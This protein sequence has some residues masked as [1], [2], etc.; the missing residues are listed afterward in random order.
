MM[1]DDVHKFKSSIAMVK[2]AF[3]KKVFTSNWK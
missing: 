3:S 2:T 1:Q